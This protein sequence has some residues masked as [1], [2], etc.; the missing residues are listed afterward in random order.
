MFEDTLFGHV[1][2]AFTGASQARQGYLRRADNGTLLFDEVGS[3]SLPAQAKLLRVI[4]TGQFRPVGSDGLVRSSFRVLAAANTDLAALVEQGGFRADL[5]HRLAAVVIRVPPLSERLEDLALLVRHFVRASPA[6]DSSFSPP[7]MAFLRSYRWPGN[8]RELRHAVAAAIALSAHPVV[9][10][11]TVRTVLGYTR[12]R[13]GG[14]TDAREMARRRLVEVLERCDW[15]TARAAEHFGVHRV[16][17]YRRM[18]RLGVPRLQDLRAAQQ[19]G[20]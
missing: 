8:V 20:P 7:A 14:P 17:I 3:L 12:Q 1:A 6:P 11:A 2:G 10:R 16:T 15:D 5:L 9:D 19:V 13:D 4:D 18:H